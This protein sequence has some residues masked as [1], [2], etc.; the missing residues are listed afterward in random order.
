MHRIGPLGRGDLVRQVLQPLP[1]DDQDIAG[2]GGSP[3]L[4]EQASQQ[5]LGCTH[6][7]SSRRT[8]ATRILL[9]PTSASACRTSARKAL[10]IIRIAEVEPALAQGPC[11]RRWSVEEA[12]VAEAD[13]RNGLLQQALDQPLSV[14]V[15][16]LNPV[17][18]QRLLDLRRAQ[19]AVERTRGGPGPPSPARRGSLPAWRLLRAFSLRSPRVSRIASAPLHERAQGIVGAS[20]GHAANR[21]ESTL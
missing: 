18:G 10:D 21:S 1:V 15:P 4:V 9:S 13:R 12:E 5:K 16:A 11:T 3:G 20:S 17:L 14:L 2:L 8:S 6:S 19:S 7:A